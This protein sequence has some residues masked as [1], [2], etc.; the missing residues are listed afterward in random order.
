MPERNPLQ[1]MK[2]D[3][4]G[5]PATSAARDVIQLAVKPGDTAYY[6]RAD[7][8]LKLGCDQHPAESTTIELE[9]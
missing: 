2:C 1:D 6:Y 3:V 9:D 5:Q 7:S 4:C 8:Q